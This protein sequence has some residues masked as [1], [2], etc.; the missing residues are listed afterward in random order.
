MFPALAS[1]TAAPNAPT[2]LPATAPATVPATD[3]SSPA[4]DPA[5]TPTAA[6]TPMSESP[7]PPP[8]KRFCSARLAETLLS[9]PPPT[10]SCARRSSAAASSRE[11]CALR[12]PWGDARAARSDQ[13]LRD[14]ELPPSENLA[15]DASRTA[16]AVTRLTKS[17]DAPASFAAAAISPG[18]ATMPLAAITRHAATLATADR[19]PGVSAACGGRA[20]SMA[21]S[22]AAVAASPDGHASTAAAA[23]FA[24]PSYP[25]SAS[26]DASPCREDASIAAATTST[27]PDAATSPIHWSRAAPPPSSANTAAT[28]LVARAP[29]TRSGA[30][31]ASPSSDASRSGTDASTYAAKGADQSDGEPCAAESPREVGSGG[32]ASYTAAASSA[33]A[34]ACASSEIPSS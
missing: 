14:H 9:A 34:L 31:R 6:P 30:V 13:S 18:V 33:A 24:S 8:P 23:A 26:S 3:T 12:A 20:S 16:R 7:E 5:T 17:L 19:A 28:A 10:R 2:A 22:E 15:P 29:A 32:S 4:A 21:P 11:K 27:L 1:L 25:P